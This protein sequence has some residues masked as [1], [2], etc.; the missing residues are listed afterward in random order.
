LNFLK[1]THPRIAATSP[2]AA[3]GTNEMKPLACVALPYST[4][5][6]TET[7]SDNATT[8]EAIAHG[9]YRSTAFDP[10]PF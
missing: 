1:A 10:G 4:S 9:L 7:A 8:S 3:V 6:T 5:G 2:M